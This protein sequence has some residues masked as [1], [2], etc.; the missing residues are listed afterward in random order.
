MATTNR[1]LKPA[2][3]LNI[4]RK[5]KPW[6]V[7]QQR[8]GI[9]VYIGDRM[10]VG[11]PRESQE[12]GDGAATRG[13]HQDHALR[14]EWTRK[15]TTHQLLYRSCYVNITIELI[16]SADATPGSWAFLGHL[17]KSLSLENIITEPGWFRYYR[18]SYR[19]RH[20]SP[21]WWWI[22]KVTILY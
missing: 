20:F 18:V 9:F 2:Q 14:H 8:L 21:W 10:Y 1:S 11:N 15:T 22:V 13:Q 5:T 12:L 16:S 19:P 6:R 17:Q 7:C 3:Q 4:G